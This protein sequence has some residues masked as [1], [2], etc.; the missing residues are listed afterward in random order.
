MPYRRRSSTSSPSLERPQTRSTEDQGLRVGSSAA[1]T[2]R[3]AR[4]ML[5]LLIGIWFGSMLVV[6]LAVPRSFQSVDLVMADPAPEISKAI[7]EIGPIRARMVLHHQISESNR[8]LL[9]GWGW[10]QLGLGLLVFGIVLFGT[11]SG[12]VAIGLAGLMLLVAAVTQFL[13]IPRLHEISRATDFAPAMAGSPAT[14]RFLVL[15]RGFVAFE[16]VIGVLGTVLLG[17]LFRR[18]ERGLN[19]GRGKIRNPDAPYGE[20]FN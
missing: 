7:R 14:D 5:I 3:L 1:H 16:A 6:V 8:M 17:L 11:K 10:A 20:Q 12:R 2:D 19:G 15:H 4:R 9:Q 13:L 18:G